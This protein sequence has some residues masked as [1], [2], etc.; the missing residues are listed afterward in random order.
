LDDPESSADDDEDPIGVLFVVD[1]NAD[2]AI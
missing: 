1:L 2:V